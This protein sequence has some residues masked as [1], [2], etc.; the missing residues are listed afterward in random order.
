MGKEA[1]GGGAVQAYLT[2]LDPPSRAALE[3]LRKAILDVA[4]DAVEGFSYG[5]PVLKLGGH[6]IAAFAAFKG[7]LSLFPMS[8]TA[9]DGMRGDLRGFKTSKGTI[10]FTLEKPLPLPLV[11]RI[12]KARLAELGAAKR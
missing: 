5:M 11:K 1:K 10:Q 9:L 4:P 7:H 12:V 8:S 2:G 6:G 3:R